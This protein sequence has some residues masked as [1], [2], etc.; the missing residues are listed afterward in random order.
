M[1]KKK[2]STLGLKLISILMAV[3]LWFYVV[4][5]GETTARQNS[6]EVELQ[7]Y[8]LA[9]DLLV[10]GPATVRIN[11]WGTPQEGEQ[12]NAFVDLEGLGEGDYELP[13]KVDSL[14]GAL[15]TTVEPRTVGVE[16]REI[17]ENI[18][19]IEHEIRQNS[20]IDINLKEVIIEPA[21]CLIRGNQINIDRITRIIAPLDLSNVTDISSIAVKLEARDED[22]QLIEEGI[23]FVPENVTA[24]IVVERNKAYKTVAVNP[25]LVGDPD[26]AYKVSQVRVEPENVSL[27][28]DGSRLAKYTNI[29]TT[30]IDLSRRNESFVESV[31]LKQAEGVQIF[32]EAVLVYVLLERVLETEENGE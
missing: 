16:L 28:G 14:E 8:N 20:G 23:R 6:Q 29:F 2:N 25:K 19:N 26:P 7:F 24:I 22:G 18:F 30:D 11:F 10:E 27:I 17:S 5:Q 32:P 13:V 12:I 15:F 9:Q 31:S 1:E 3:L 4:N 21:T